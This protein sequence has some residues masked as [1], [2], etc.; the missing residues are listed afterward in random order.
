MFVDLL[1]V[2]K[3]LLLRKT[4]TLKTCQ[5]SKLVGKKI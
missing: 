4:D 2:F 5:K 1:D 3:H